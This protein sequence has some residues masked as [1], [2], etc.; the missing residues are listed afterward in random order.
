MMRCMANNAYASL[1]FISLI[2]GLCAFRRL[3]FIDVDCLHAHIR[4]SF[5]KRLYLYACSLL[6][7]LFYCIRL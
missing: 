4:I 3:M 1:A 5:M 2:S 6:L 7:R